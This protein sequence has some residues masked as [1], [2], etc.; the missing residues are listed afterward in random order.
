M[1][2]LII[3]VLMT[4]VMC[5]SANRMAAQNFVSDYTK[6][7]IGGTVGITLDGGTD[8]PDMIGFHGAYFFNPK[9]GAGM[10]GRYFQHPNYKN[11]VFAPAFF[12][13]WG[14]GNSKL[15][16]PTRIGLGIDMHTYSYAETL[17]DEFVQTTENLFAW[18]ASAGIAIR[19]YNRFS[20]SVNAEYASSFEWMD[21]QYLGFN[22]GLS[23]HF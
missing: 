14:S 10:V 8:L 20:I 11:L 2:R 15:Y 9:F 5:L 23:F 17:Q 7:Y 13:H 22:L 12:A 3:S 16:F 18:Y 4:L 19:P 21:S 6:L 1:K